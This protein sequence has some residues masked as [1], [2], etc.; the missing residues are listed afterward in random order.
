MTASR[1]AALAVASK[2]GRGGAHSKKQEVAEAGGEDDAETSLA[3]EP[4]TLVCRNLQ[5]F[6]DAPKGVH[7]D[8]PF[9]PCFCFILHR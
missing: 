2:F 5:Y 4:I 7:V 3:F 1:V 9:T 6:V 8:Q